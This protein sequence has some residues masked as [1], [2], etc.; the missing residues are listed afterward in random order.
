MVPPTL[1][2]EQ[3]ERLIAA[4]SR[5]R[6]RE[7]AF[8]PDEFWVVLEST[9]ADILDATK[10]AQLVV[11]IRQ[12]WAKEALLSRRQDGQGVVDAADTSLAELE[13]E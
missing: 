13:A 12:R 10:A 6:V 4:E 8:E 7:L 3:K 11:A 9:I 5:N 2:P 1:T